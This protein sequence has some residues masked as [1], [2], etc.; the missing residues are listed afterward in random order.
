MTTLTALGSVSAHRKEKKK[1]KQQHKTLAF[2]LSNKT[3]D[4]L[5]YLLIGV[6]TDLK[7]SQNPPI[8]QR[9]RPLAII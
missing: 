5:K 1:T 2:N 3:E 6:K 9:Q 7:W 4:A 8:F